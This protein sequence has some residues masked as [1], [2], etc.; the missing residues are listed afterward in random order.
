MKLSYEAYRKQILDYFNSIGVSSRNLY[1]ELV[2]QSS[3]VEVYY[4]ISKTND[5]VQLHSHSF[6]E[7][8]FC[9]CGN[10]Q[11]LLGDK[12]YRVQKGDIII[13]PPGISHRPL[14]LE[15]LTEPYERIALWLNTDFLN[16]AIEDSPDLAYALSQ[17][18]KRGSYLLRSSQATWSGL[19]A[20]FNSL[21]TESQQ[22]RLG[23]QVC[24]NAGALL[25]M[26]HISR[27]FYYQE[28]SVPSE[29]KENLVDEVFRFIDANLSEKITLESIAS[30]FLVSK[31]TISHLFQKQMGVSFYHCVIQRRLIAAKN[32]ILNGMPL[33]EVWE[34]CGFADY[35]S[36]YRQFKKEYGISPKEFLKLH[37]KR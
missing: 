31:S 33:N 28:V 20:G 26:A 25:L 12:R 19:Y 10:V 13:I 5:V 24:I 29:E 15:E 34:R 9:N 36:F 3:S 6:Y 4:D 17:C 32:S 30:H 21:W 14:F 7:I 35:S 1:Q 37:T 16:R 11:Y 8:L 27:T 23:W 2:M 22:K 18:E